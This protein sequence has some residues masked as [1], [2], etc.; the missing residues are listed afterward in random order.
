MNAATRRADVLRGARTTSIFGLVWW[1]AGFGTL[2]SP[3]IGI[4]LLVAGIALTVAIQVFAQRQ[5]RDLT[6]I[7]PPPKGQNAYYLR[8][9]I[10]E[11]LLIAVAAVLCNLL[12]RPEW[13]TSL[14]VIVVGL[15]FIPLAALYRQPR[16][17]ILAA[18]MTA[19]GVISLVLVIAD[20]LSGNAWLTVPAVGAG[21]AIF[22]DAAHGVFVRDD[23]VAEPAGI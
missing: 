14:V 18:V 2:A 10:T 16:W 12:D 11:I 22:A 1:F 5:L 3:A 19:I 9:F 20:V 4:P 13:V 15:H 17:N 21:L 7:Q 23:R 6:G 8:V